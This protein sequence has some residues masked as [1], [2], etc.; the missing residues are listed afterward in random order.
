M[1]RLTCLLWLAVWLL[2][3]GLFPAGTPL[4]WGQVR[5][6]AEA[7]ADSADLQ[8]QIQRGE[9]LESE[10]K[11]AEASA[12]YEESLRAHP[13]RRELEQRLT[14]ARTFVDLKRRYS[15]STFTAALGTVSQQQALDEYYEVLQK[16]QTYHVNLP[17]WTAMAR[18]G[19]THLH[20]ALDCPEFRQ[21]NAPRITPEQIAGF[22]AWLQRTGGNRTLA[23]AAQARDF[24]A[25]IAVAAQ[26]QIGVPAPATIVEFTCGAVASLD[27]YSSF[28]TAGQ[29]EELFSQIEGNFVGLGIELRAHGDALEIVSVI[30]NSPADLGGMRAGD[31]IVA[32][33]G[34]ATSEET[35]DAAADSLKG[36]EGSH[37]QV[38]L[39]GP[40]GERRELRLV[41]RRIDVP[42][43]EDARIV[44]RDAGI[45]YLKL[46]SFQKTTYQEVRDTLW[47]LYR[48]GMKSLIIDVRG[49]PGGLLTA[50]VEVADLFVSEGSIV[51]TRGRSPREN[52]DHRA[53][54]VGTWRVPL[55]VL[56]DHDTASASEIFAAAIRDHRR[57]EVV[58]QPTYG[59][60]SVQGIFPLTISTAGVRLTTAKFYSPNGQAISQRGVQPTVPIQMVAKPVSDE[61]PP[62][63]TTSQVDVVLEASLQ[64]VRQALMTQQQAAGVR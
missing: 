7:L 22:R 11:W 29:L 54:S 39:I 59:K 20:Y 64:R 25:T 40:A 44:D 14:R 1:G 53:H 42:S 51:S 23:S 10:Q 43:V 55:T 21:A 4:A 8:Q 27:R 5:I 38:T 32:V 16:V 9:R 52:F 63:A 28:L 33:E 61:S 30:P 15:D 47:T 31:R 37:V 57:G 26:R 13:G 6:P 24:A 56:I 49:N 3:G 45:A 34:T 35:L 18:R 62:L 36:P 41:R 58:G 50:S 60:G 48:E 17:E 46:T 2:L 19:L 12:H